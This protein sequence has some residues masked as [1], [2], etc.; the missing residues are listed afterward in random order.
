MSRKCPVCLGLSRTRLI[1]LECGGSGEVRRT[2]KG[3]VFVRRK[4]CN[5]TADIEEGEGFF[6]NICQIHKRRSETN[7]FDGDWSV[8]LLEAAGHVT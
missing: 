7:P 4:G 8:E 2:F 1:C 3:R 6:L 5:C